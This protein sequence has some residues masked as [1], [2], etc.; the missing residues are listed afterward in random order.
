MLQF[1]T[2]AGA[3]GG[4]PCDYRPSGHNL[5]GVPPD[6]AAGCVAVLGGSATLGKDVDRPFPCLVEQ[7]CG[8][9]VVNLGAPNAGPD[10]YLSDPAVLEAASRADVVVIQVPGAEALTNPFYSV[11]SRRN[12]RFVAA[13]PALRALFPGLDVTDI[14]FTRHLLLALEQADS[15]RFGL[16]VRT[17]K[18]AWLARMRDLLV[19]LPP[20]RILLWLADAP[21]PDDAVAI[22]RGAEPALVDAAMLAGLSPLVSCVTVVVPSPAARAA[23]HAARARGG[24]DTATL[25]AWCLPGPAAHVEIARQLSPQIMA[26]LKRD[27]PMGL[28]ARPAL[29]LG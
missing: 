6:P 22:P 16:V 5:A 25:G 1:Q 7:T 20:R 10:Y 8:I 4:F 29:A 21:P 28:A 2:G 19:R 17:L 13:T 12:D 9:P 27:G 14:H 18:A 26:L 11:H 15:E 3:S 23:D 24:A